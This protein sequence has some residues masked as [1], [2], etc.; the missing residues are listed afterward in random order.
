MNIFYYNKIKILSKKIS[1]SVKKQLCYKKSGDRIMRRNKFKTQSIFKSKIFIL[2]MVTIFSTSCQMRLEGGLNSATDYNTIPQNYEE[3]DS[4]HPAQS[5]PP[6]N[7]DFSNLPRE[8]NNPPPQSQQSLPATEPTVQPATSVNQPTHPTEPAAIPT[9][10]PSATIP[11]TT[12]AQ[13]PPATSTPATPTTPPV[14]SQ[15]PSQTRP[16]LARPPLTHQSQIG[17]PEASTIIKN[18]Q[19]VM[20]EEGK[21][22]G[23][24]CNF[25]V[26]R[27]LQV[28][29]FPKGSYLAADF[30]LYAEKNF[31]YYR[32]KNFL[33]N[34]A[35]N[36]TEKLRK[37]IWNYPERTPFILQW[38]RAQVTG[39]I[40]IMERIGD[41]L[42]IYQASLNKY[43]ARKSLT[44]IDSLLRDYNRRVLT[45]YSEMTPY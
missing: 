41:Q 7:E 39:H 5:S 16:P 42:I 9:T 17:T 24:A 33:K 19:K 14:V 25:Y 29:G 23:P 32:A 31:K 30:D 6:E 40:A 1:S 11:P 28:S 15:N 18:A 35:Q 3:L 12:A 34:S 13:N 27:V 38:S 37:Y 2:L 4:S 22:I 8:V 36:D 10:Q 45:V 44:T 21:K 43:T 20:V 26:Q